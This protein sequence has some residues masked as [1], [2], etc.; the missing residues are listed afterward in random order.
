MPDLEIPPGTVVHIHLGEPPAPRAAWSAAAEPGNAFA[1]AEAAERRPSSGV[2]RA[3]AAAGLLAFGFSAG[4][5]VR[6]PEGPT[7]PRPVAEAAAPAPIPAAPTPG[8]APLDRPASPAGAWRAWP[9]A[10]APTRPPGPAA[11]RG[12]GGAGAEAPTGFE[13]ALRAPPQVLPPPAAAAPSGG[14]NTFGL[15]VPG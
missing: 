9:E 14:R 4:W 15:E 8:P 11:A 10:P 3:L 1:P 7:L 6:G 12:D 5:L 13:R 2:G